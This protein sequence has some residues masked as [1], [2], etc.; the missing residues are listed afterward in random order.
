[1]ASDT[2]P[3][4]VSPEQEETARHCERIRVDTSTPWG[5]AAIIADIEFDDAQDTRFHGSLHLFA[6]HSTNESVTYPADGTDCNIPI[7]WIST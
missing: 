7:R 3:Y 5:K 2:Q 4:P 1:M 6:R